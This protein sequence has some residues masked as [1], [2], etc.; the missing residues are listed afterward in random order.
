MAAKVVGCA[1][2]VA[3]DINDKR[4]EVARDLGATHIVNGSKEDAVAAV[5]KISGGEGVQYSLNVP[6][7][8]KSRAKLLIP[9]A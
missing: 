7:C 5:R 3:V 4:L 9:S 1:T 6:A 8:Q 2:I